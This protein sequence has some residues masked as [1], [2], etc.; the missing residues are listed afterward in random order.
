MPQKL[1]DEEIRKRLIRLQNLERLY[2]DLKLKYQALQEENIALKATIQAQSLLIE[3]LKLRIEE[4]ERMVFGRRKKPDQPVAPSTNGSSKRDSSKRPSLS[5]RRPKPDEDE[6]ASVERHPLSACPD[7][8]SSLT[9]VTIVER[10]VEDLLPL[11]D[12]WKALKRITKHLI[13]TGYCGHC[14]E[15]KSAIP[16]SAHAVTLGAN[17]K[18]FVSFGTVV[19]RLSYEQLKGFLSGT[20]RCSLSDGEIANILVD[21]AN[22]LRPE[23]ER[24]KESIRRQIGAHY[25]ETTWPV[26]KETQGNYAWTMTGT[27]NQEAVFLLGRTRGKGNAEELKGESNH[28]GI[29]DDYGAYK[30]LFRHHQL[31]W[32]HPHR[33]LRDLAESTTLS[34][35]KREHCRTVFETFATLYHDVGNVWLRP[36]V[37]EER[38]ATKADLIKRFDEIAVSHPL[39]PEKLRIIKERLRLRRDHYF[40]CLTIPGIP[41]DNNKAERSLRHL[42]LKR[43]SSFGSRTQ[44][45]AEVMSVLYSVLLSWWWK[46]KQT[47]FQEYATAFDSS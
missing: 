10:Y 28:T 43:K 33:K 35:E 41:P 9:K 26:Q 6:I 27:E 32:S 45:G 37:M 5:Y 24:L 34:P 31:C 25:D 21:E 30:N 1:S 15:R 7:C 47:F 40:V 22:L 39:D 23:F 14:K 12:W 29:T 3:Q 4:L 38:L 2:A 42:V 11:S 19:L 18:Q 46:S 17:V 20:V 13:T 16:I 36:F 44:K 8:G